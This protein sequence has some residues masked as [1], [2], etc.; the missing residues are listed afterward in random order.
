MM[1]TVEDAMLFTERQ[2]LPVPID[3][4]GKCLL[5]TRVGG[6]DNDRTPCETRIF[7]SKPSPSI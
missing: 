2:I 6:A 1:L 4:V 5:R 7:F 3:F